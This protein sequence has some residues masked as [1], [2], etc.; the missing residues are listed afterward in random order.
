MVAADASS[1]RPIEPM[2]S[3]DGKCQRELSLDRAGRPTLCGR[4]GW[5]KLQGRNLCG[6][7]AAETMRSIEAGHAATVGRN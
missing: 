3:A 7:H 6:R 1:Q 4:P 2:R 5:I